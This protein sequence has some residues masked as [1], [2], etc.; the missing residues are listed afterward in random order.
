[1]GK[2]SNLCP[3]EIFL[4]FAFPNWVR[5]ARAS[6][7]FRWQTS[8]VAMKTRRHRNVTVVFTFARSY[9]FEYIMP[10]SEFMW[11]REKSKIIVNIYCNCLRRYCNCYNIYVI[12]HNYVNYNLTIILYV[13]LCL[14]SSSRWA[15]YYKITAEKKLPDFGQ[16][17][18]IPSVS[19]YQLFHCS[20]WSCC[21]WYVLFWTIRKYNMV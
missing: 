16:E 11:F 6:C 15:C 19:I 7:S 1:M 14:L 5:A 17:S 21:Y 3:P 13:F 2:N 12:R 10:V 8:F 20:S 18:K 9:I 4:I